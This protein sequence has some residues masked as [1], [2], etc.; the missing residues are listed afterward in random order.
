MTIKSGILYPGND[1]QGWM[2][3]EELQWLFQVAGHMKTIAEIGVWKGR[4]T[5]ALL[6]A[7]A[8]VVA[9]DNWQMV[10][11]GYDPAQAREEFMKN[12]EEFRRRGQLQIMEMSSLAAAEKL[13]GQVDTVFIDADH[14]YE[15]FKADL[16]GWIPKARQLICGHDYKPSWPGVQRAVQE[17]FGKDFRT[18]KGIWFHYL[19]GPW[20]DN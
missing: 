15:P 19:A 8:R 16:M 18:F 12:T 6:S 17:V 2:R 4:S 11:Q 5:L 13:P 3:L 10:I 7:G 1:I 20:G 9:V 14:R